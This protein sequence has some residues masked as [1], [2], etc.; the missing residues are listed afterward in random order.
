MKDETREKLLAEVAHG[1]EQL[2]KK[3]KDTHVLWS[4]EIALLDSAGELVL[5]GPLTQGLR[6]IV[7]RVH[8]A[9][10]LTE[11]SGVAAAHVHIRENLCPVCSEFHENPDP[12][13]DDEDD[14][15]S[16]G[17]AYL[18]DQDGPAPEPGSE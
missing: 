15:G 4:V 13:E 5:T 16:A 14:D 1:L 2:A 7:E 3:G 6:W 8:Q 17:P 10:D 12:E 9:P 18:D 11:L